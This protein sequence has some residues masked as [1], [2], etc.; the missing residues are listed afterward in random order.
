MNAAFLHYQVPCRKYFVTYIEKL[1]QER[2]QVIVEKLKETEHVS[3]T[4]DLITS[5][6]NESIITVTGHF[7]KQ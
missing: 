6:Q 5:L 1:F 2:S 3:V 7:L 4:T